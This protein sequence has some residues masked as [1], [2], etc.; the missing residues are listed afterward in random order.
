M[1]LKIKK[2]LNLWY[3]FEK[4]KG[5]SLSQYSQLLDKLK[6][7]ISI[8][9]AKKKKFNKNQKIM[10][11]FI[12][13]V[14]NE[15]QFNLGNISIKLEKG[16]ENK[17]F[18]HILLK[19]YH[20]NDLDTIDILNMIDIYIRG[21]KLQNEGLSNRYLT[22]Y[23]RINKQK[24]YRLILNENETPTMIITSYRKV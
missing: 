4:F 12:N 22:A 23:M 19:H 21:M 16:D 5:K 9:S 11:K 1:R 14:T 10:I 7:D 3:N 15:A 2:I 20:K 8:I 6:K 13:G 17:G 18:K 24:E